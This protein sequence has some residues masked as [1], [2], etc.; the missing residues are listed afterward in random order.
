MAFFWDVASCSLV[1]V[2]RRFRGA[3][4]LRHQGAL[5][6]EA[7]SKLQAAAIAVLCG[8][9][10]DPTAV[11]AVRCLTGSAVAQSRSSAVLAILNILPLPRHLSVCG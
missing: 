2:Y 11:I 9:G 1:E 4:C 8:P 6:A 10:L 7:A 5:M 3:Y